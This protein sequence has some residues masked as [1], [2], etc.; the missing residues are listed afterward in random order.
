MGCSINLQAEHIPEPGAVRGDGLCHSWDDLHSPWG[1][2]EGLQISTF[3]NVWSFHDCVWF[4]PC[5][6]L[7]FASHISI[8]PGE[9]STW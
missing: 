8:V 7:G 4:A 1:G 5:F 3:E 2:G 9:V 6:A